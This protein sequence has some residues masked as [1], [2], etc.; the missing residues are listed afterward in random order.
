[1]DLE[2]NLK[3]SSDPSLF[4]TLKDIEVFSMNT[5]CTLLL[6]WFT[7]HDVS[8]SREIIHLLGQILSPLEN[9]HQSLSEHEL[10]ILLASAYLHDVGMQFAKVEGISIDKLTSKEY[11]TIRKRHAE[12]SFDI[13]LKRVKQSLDRDDFHLPT[14]EE[15]YLPVIAWVSKGHATEFFEEAIQHFQ[16]NPATP[17]N[18]PVRGKLLAAL[19]L[20][21]DELDLQCKR[22]KFSETSKF[23]LSDFSAVHWY[24]HHYVSHV[25]IKNGAVSLTLTFPEE[26]DEYKGMIKELIEAKL[27]A[28]IDQVNPVLSEA[29]SG[30]L[31]LSNIINIQIKTDDTSTKRPLP[32][33]ALAELKKMVKKEPPERPPTPQNEGHIRRNIPN[34]TRIFTGRKDELCQFKDAFERSNLISI[35]GLGGIGKTEF[36]AQCIKLYL[37]QGNVIWFECSPD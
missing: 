14:I 13:I 32:V 31:H 20:I 35:E 23:D 8:H 28:Q 9:T 16:E 17:R 11:E 37:Q 29:T 6:P 19:L 3:Q 30:L 26:A 15:E 4:R 7:S 21:A 22:A 24:K 18:R 34:P 1:M 25:E 5:W 2:E 33:G 27:K 36:A 10:F 12:E